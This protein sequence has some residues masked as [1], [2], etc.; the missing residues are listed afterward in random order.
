MELFNFFQEITCGMEK[1][2]NLKNSTEEEIWLS[3]GFSSYF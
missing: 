3:A 2:K 1:A